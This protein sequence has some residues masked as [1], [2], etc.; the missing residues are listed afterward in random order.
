[1]LPGMN[2]VIDDVCEAD[3]MLN[4]CEDEGAI[5]AHL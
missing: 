5:A 2:D 1:M 4:L 3:A